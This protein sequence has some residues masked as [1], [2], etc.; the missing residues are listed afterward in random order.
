MLE[1]GTGVGV[2]MAL[3]FAAVDDATLKE[4]P[5]PG[6]DISQI[7]QAFATAVKVQDRPAAIRPHY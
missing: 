1:W 2:D 7:L 5:E 6:H 3:L 4:L